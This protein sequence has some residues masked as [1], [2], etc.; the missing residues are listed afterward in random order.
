MV[1]ASITEQSGD[2]GE[3]REVIFFEGKYLGVG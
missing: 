1:V 3:A 2:S